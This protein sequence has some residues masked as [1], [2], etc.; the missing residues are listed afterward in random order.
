LVEKR[1]DAV[2]NA[3]TAGGIP[4]SRITTENRSDAEAESDAVGTDSA[5]QTNEQRVEVRIGTGERQNTVAHEFGHVFG[6]SDEYTEGA[7]V[8]GQDAWHD[9]TAVNAGISAGAGVERSD[10]I[11]STGNEVRP[12][13]YSTFAWALNM[14]TES[15]RGSRMWHVKE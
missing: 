9:H 4:G 7:R 8:A 14:L 15:V 1:L 12:Q 5:S 3:V 2:Q 10:N 13:H 11:I 6:L